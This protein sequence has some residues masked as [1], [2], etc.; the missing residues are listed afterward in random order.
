VI[1]SLRGSLADVELAGDA[2]AEATVDVGGVG[3][4]VV[5]GG[6]TAA[7]LPPLGSPVALSVFTHVRESAITLY[8]F[9]SKEERRTFEQLIGA[10]GIGPALAIAILGVLSPAGLAHAVAVGDLDALMSVPGVGKKTAQRLA[11]ELAGRLD[12]VYLTA[13]ASGAVTDHRQSE[14]REAL[15]TLGYGADEVRDVLDRLPEDG[16]IEEL[17]RLALR[18]LAPTR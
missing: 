10:H 15:T 1:G 5:L 2:N 11:M 9:S 8:G 12:G 4:R 14:L 7:A 16:S 3:Y 13:P 17:L 6:R 18:E